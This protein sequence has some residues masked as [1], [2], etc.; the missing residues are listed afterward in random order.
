MS[1]MDRSNTARLFMRAF[2]ASIVVNAVLGIWALLAGDF[3][4]TQGKVLATSFLVSAAMLSVLVDTPAHRRG[5]L[6]PVPAIGAATGAAGFA[7][8]IVALW[9]EAD[10]D[11][12][13]KVAGSLL[14]VAA[15]ATLAA[16]LALIPLAPRLHLAQVI[17][18]AL[19]AVLA[20]TILVVIWAESDNDTMGRLIGVEGVLVAAGTL[21]IPALSRFANPDDGAVAPGARPAVRFCPSCGRAVDDG[22]TGRPTTCDHCGSTFQVAFGVVGSAVDDGVEEAAGAGP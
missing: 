22:V 20:V 14:V 21:L 16:N 3:G 17:T 4:A 1:V 18:R 9:V 8:L 19:I 2:I 5:V 12:W 15:G 11:E 10:A 13:F 6:R 7:W